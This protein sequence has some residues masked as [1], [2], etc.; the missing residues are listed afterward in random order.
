MQ[1]AKILLIGDPKS[2]FTLYR[3]VQ[4]AGMRP[5]HL[6]KDGSLESIL[7]LKRKS[8]TSAKSIETA[9]QESISQAFSIANVIMVSAGFFA[10][11][12]WK[13]SVSGKSYHEA[14]GDE[15]PES[16]ASEIQNFCS[17]LLKNVNHIIVFATEEELKV[18]ILQY[19]E[20]QDVPLTVF[21]LANPRSSNCG[22]IGTNMGK[23]SP[24]VQPM[25]TDVNGVNQGQKKLSNMPAM[26][27]PLVVNSNLDRFWRSHSIMEEILKLE[28]E[29]TTVIERPLDSIDVILSPSAGFEFVMISM[30]DINLCFGARNSL[31]LWNCIYNKIF[32]SVQKAS[33]SIGV[34]HVILHMALYE[35]EFL[36]VLHSVR[37]KILMDGRALSLEIQ[38]EISFEMRDAK[39][40][41]LRL[42][43]S[44]LQLWHQNLSNMYS[45]GDSPSSF[46]EYCL[47]CP[48]LNPHSAA[49][50]ASSCS[51]DEIIKQ[52]SLYGVYGLPTPVQELIPLRILQNF[53]RDMLQNRNNMRASAMAGSFAFNKDE[54]P[55]SNRIEFTKQP[56]YNEISQS[57][58]LGKLKI[59]ASERLDPSIVIFPEIQREGR[60]PSVPGDFEKYHNN[61]DVSLYAEA[62]ILDNL[63]DCSIT[64]KHKETKDMKQHRNE[65]Y[66]IQNKSHCC[67]EGDVQPELD[68]FG[69][70]V[71]PED[72]RLKDEEGAD[73]YTTPRA[74][75]WGMIQRPIDFGYDQDKNKNILPG[76]YPTDK[77]DVELPYISEKNDSVQWNSMAYCQ[78]S[79]QALQNSH[80]LDHIEI[81]PCDQNNS[82]GR[83]SK[84]RATHDNLVEFLPS[85]CDY[86]AQNPCNKYSQDITPRR[87]R[88]NVIHGFL[89]SSAAPFDNTSRKRKPYGPESLTYE[90]HESGNDTVDSIEALMAPS[91]LV[92][93]DMAVNPIENR[94]I[95]FSD[96]VK[97]LQ[98]FHYH[99]F[100]KTS[101]PASTRNCS[102]IL[103]D[104]QNHCR[105]KRKKNRKKFTTRTFRQW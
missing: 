43:R 105:G 90:E 22:S 54:T 8:F 41:M 1:D 95:R 11:T 5:C 25:Q 4:D 91:S 36:P 69:V 33:I 28:N 83:V 73:E 17:L 38:L 34:F 76:L 30:D 63:E 2:F 55:L 82:H 101:S 67:S 40:S 51:P 49:L 88:G 39:A 58:T 50:V 3:I 14:E 29:G 72:L 98:Q 42:L 74:A 31:N 61:T 102:Q 96:A 32:P 104:E 100:H 57:R 89:E 79:P 48:S 23:P 94:P 80:H 52:M 13:S 97:R 65:N 93:E 66:F 26:D 71:N 18:P 86:N 68:E 19:L 15:I 6:D 44:Y 59:D 87:Y 24:L 27:W 56:K 78:C 92:Y 21:E 47:S 84:M 16:S 9:I 75:T 53:V 70:V 77:R 81:Y 103:S 35:P 85:Y 12:K 46:E 10:K 64:F 60:S 99:G 7:I 62:P 20:P 45:I 37:D